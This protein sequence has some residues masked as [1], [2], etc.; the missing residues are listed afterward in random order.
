LT[1]RKKSVA[2]NANDNAISTVR[3]IIKTENYNSRS[4]QQISN[5]LLLD[6]AHSKAAQRRA[7]M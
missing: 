4:I 7:G 5:L 2:V 3:P 6:C 1:R